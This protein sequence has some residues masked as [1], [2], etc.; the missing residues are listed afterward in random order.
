MAEELVSFASESHCSN[1][2]DNFVAGNEI[3][4]LF[5]FRRVPTSRMTCF[6]NF[7][8]S[9]HKRTNRTN[10][11]NSHTLPERKRLLILRNL[12]PFN[13][14][15]SYWLSVAFSCG[16]KTSL[17]F[18]ADKIDQ[19]DPCWPH[20]K[21]LM[22][23]RR[24]LVTTRSGQKSLQGNWNV[25]TVFS[26]PPSSSDRR[27]WL[28]RVPNEFPFLSP[29]RTFSFLGYCARKW[30]QF[31]WWDLLPQWLQLPRSRLR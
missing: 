23:R 29:C 7:G 26:K 19:T 28:T 2:A 17:T 25:S 10:E 9:P 18:S 12:G 30:H 1:W 4:K 6:T 11:M 22:N 14:E 24:Q 13:S 20:S 21:S 27:G 31:N 15:T 16:I 8:H 3:Y 5:T